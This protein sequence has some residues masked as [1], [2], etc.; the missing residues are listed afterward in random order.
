M[1]SKGEEVGVHRGNGD[2]RGEA[3]VDYELIIGFIAI[4]SR[5]ARS[6]SVAQPAGSD[7]RARNKG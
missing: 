3:V 5:T 2:L 6:I 7:A 4:P 1:R